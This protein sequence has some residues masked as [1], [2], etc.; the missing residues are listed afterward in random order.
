MMPSEIFN[1]FLPPHTQHSVDCL[2]EF[3]R[4]FERWP[5]K[6]L[7]AAEQVRLVALQSVTERELASKDFGSLPILWKSPGDYNSRGV[8]FQHAVWRLNRALE[9]MQE[10]AVAD[11]TSAVQY[12]R[13]RSS[14][15][16][17]FI[18]AGDFVKIGFAT[19]VD[20]RLKALETGSP[21][22]LVVLSTERGTME[23]EAYYHRK[24][25]DL[26]ARGEWFRYGDAIRA[27]LGKPV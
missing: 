18:Q 21:V 24:F 9:I 20:K 16:I 5:V 17:Y 7:T 11:A 15:W 13:P 25:A 3:V 6:R 4:R 14:G 22:D 23:D 2:R 1:I 27:H 12:A 19:D 8:D 26:R 10:R